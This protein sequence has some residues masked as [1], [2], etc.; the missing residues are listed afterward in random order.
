MGYLC[1]S[2]SKSILGAPV[3][4]F[5]FIVKMASVRGYLKLLRP[6]FLMLLMLLV[7]LI[8]YVTATE[9]NVEAGSDSSNDF[10]E[11][12]QEGDDDEEEVPVEV[13]APQAPTTPPNREQGMR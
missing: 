8:T 7:L 9:D 6:W 2:T 3:G 13:E 11:F 4:H 10:A 12:E 5:D 1:I